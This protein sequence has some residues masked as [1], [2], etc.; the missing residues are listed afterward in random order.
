ML[1]I[2]KILN[3]VTMTTTITMATDMNV[4][5]QGLRAHWPCVSS[6]GTEYTTSLTV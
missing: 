2:R 4:I 1:Q 6:S 5:F 3:K